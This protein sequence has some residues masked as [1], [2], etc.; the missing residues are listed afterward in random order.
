MRKR[1]DTLTAFYILF[2]QKREKD[3]QADVLL[4]SISHGLGKVNKGKKAKKKI[5][6]PRAVEAVELHVCYFNLP[7]K[8]TTSVVFI[9]PYFV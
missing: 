2:S 8:F 3:K 5:C 9:M 4:E 1:G 7:S 6:A